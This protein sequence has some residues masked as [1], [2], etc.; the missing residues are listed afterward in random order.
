MKPFDKAAAMRGARVCHMDGKPARI[1]CF[2]SLDPLYSILAIVPDGYGDEYVFG[3]SDEGQA[4]ISG[5]LLSMDDNITLMM[6]DDDYKE[7]LERGEYGT[8]ATPAAPDPAP[9]PIPDPA[10]SPDP[11]DEFKRQAALELIRIMGAPIGS[12]YVTDIVE[13]VNGIADGLKSK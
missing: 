2:H 4:I 12:R 5:K 6:A 1:L 10:P 11:W 7:K 13:K 9:A 8:T 3:Y